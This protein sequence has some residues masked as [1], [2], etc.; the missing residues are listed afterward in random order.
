MV[1]ETLLLALICKDNIQGAEDGCDKSL[2][3]GGT[4]SQ[5]QGTVSVQKQGLSQ[6]QL[7][8]QPDQA[9]ITNV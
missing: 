1:F 3:K 4:S 6:V 7:G 2:R 5:L 9:F 8:T